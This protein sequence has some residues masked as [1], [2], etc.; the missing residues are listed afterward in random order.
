PRS[1]AHQVVARASRTSPRCSSC[2]AIARRLSPRFTSKSTSA[3]WSARGASSAEATAA[4][5]TAA[6]SS[7]ANARTAAR[8]ITSAPRPADDHGHDAALADQIAQRA[9]VRGE[10]L[11][12][13]RADRKG[14]HGRRI[15]YGQAD[16][17]LAEVESEDGA[18]H[19]FRC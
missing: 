6:S 1:R 12:I 9:D 16:P 4:A 7:A 19:G 11:A 10:S 3:P 5:V 8:A 15:G 13:E 18:F 17:T 2:V 14:D